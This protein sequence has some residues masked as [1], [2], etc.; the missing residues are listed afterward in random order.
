MGE[1]N[2]NEIDRS[3]D[4]ISSKKH[5]LAIFITA[6][7]KTGTNIATMSNFF[8]AYVDQLTHELNESTATD[9]SDSIP[10]ADVSIAVELLNH[11]RMVSR[12]G[13]D[14][15][16]DFESLPTDVKDKLAD[17][18]YHLGESRQVD[19]NARAVILNQ[20]EVRVKDV[21]AK[22]VARDPGRLNTVRSIANQMQLR[23]IYVK[24]QDIQEMQGYQIDRDRDRDIITPFLDA[25]DYTVQAQ[26]TSD[27]AEQVKY[28]DKALD[29]LTT[30]THSLYTDLDT[31]AKH[32]ADKTK[33][34]VFQPTWLIRKYIRFLA[35]D[36]QLATKFVGVQMHIKDY[37]G[38]AKG[39]EF[40]WEEYQAAIKRFF[41]LP[42]NS[43]MQSAAD[44]VHL[45]F[46]Y[47]SSNRNYWLDLSQEMKPVIDATYNEVEHNKVLVVSLED[48]KNNE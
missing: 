39:A 16:L 29:R 48:P 3:S 44:L 6:E 40:E 23:Q 37:L 25:R 19:G 28:L 9:K 46:P 24:L 5:E 34:P 47:D 7:D 38:D 10:V 11:A 42:I 22:E 20:D 12:A 36:L 35:C 41:T 30:A 21:T 17:G 1:N 4:E 8:D 31:T 14:F 32:L 15:V 18:T 27:K 45:Y 2:N 33:F 43:R 13:S 26:Q